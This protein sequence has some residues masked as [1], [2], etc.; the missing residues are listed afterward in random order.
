MGSE[1][2]RKRWPAIADADRV[3]PGEGVKDGESP[4][5]GAVYRCS[6]VLP[7]TR[8]SL[9][10]SAEGRNGTRPGSGHAGPVLQRFG[11]GRMAELLTDADL[12]AWLEES[13]LNPGPCWHLTAQ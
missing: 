2:A 5:T 8:K 3:V 1:F 13:S 6:A 10:A 12:D 11:I 7:R 4:N 9:S